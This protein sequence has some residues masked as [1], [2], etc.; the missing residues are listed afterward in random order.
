MSISHHLSDETLLDY[1]AGCLPQSLEVVIACHLTL[2]PHCRARSNLADNVGGA[3]LKA[4]EAVQTSATAKDILAMDL[5][6]EHAEPGISDDKSSGVVQPFDPVVSSV[7]RPLGRLLPTD[8]DDLP[9]KRMVPGIKQYNL[10]DQPR[11]EGAFKLLNLSPGVVLSQ[12]SHQDR[13]LTM[14]LSG[15]YQ[16][17]IGRFKAGDIADLDEDI[18]HQ[19]VVDTDEPC[20]VLIA[21]TSPVRFSGVLGKMIQPFVGL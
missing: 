14:V 17:E 19:P 4:S 1:S 9:W 10:S 13:E 16:D 6:P 20:V 8:L 5:L 3:L 15:S 18:E 2:C 11:K 12:H 21:T 7:P